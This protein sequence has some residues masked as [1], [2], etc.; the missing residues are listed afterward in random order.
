MISVS[1]DMFLER[2]CWCESCDFNLL[3]KIES[4][5][6]IIKVFNGLKED[7]LKND[8]LFSVDFVFG[9]GIFMGVNGNE[10]FLK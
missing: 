10:K 9:E 7:F 5:C 4:S 8:I 6:D 3:K 1:F 2:I